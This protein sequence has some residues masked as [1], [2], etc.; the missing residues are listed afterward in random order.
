MPDDDSG[1]VRTPHSA[2]WTYLHTARRSYHLALGAILVAFVVLAAVYWRAIPPLEAPGEGGAYAIVAKRLCH[3]AL[4]AC[5]DLTKAVSSA[6]SGDRLLARPPLYAWLASASTFW[7]SPI[8]E[9][10]CRPNIYASLWDPETRGNKNAVLHTDSQDGPL[11]GVALAL[12][13]LRAL[14]VLTSLGTIILTYGL[15]R[16]ISPTRPAVALGASALVAFNP[17]FVFIGA[18][19]GHEAPAILLTTASLYCCLRI[20]TGAD[21]LLR[22]Q[23]RPHPLAERWPALS[24]LLWPSIIWR[25]LGAGLLVGLTALAASYGPALLLPLLWACALCYKRAPSEERIVTVLAALAGLGASLATSAWWY[26]ASGWT[27]TVAGFSP[28][29]WLASS[30]SFPELL[31]YTYDRWIVSYWGL[32]G[33]GNVRM[34]SGLAS[35][36]AILGSAGSIGLLLVAARIRWRRG[37]LARYAGHAVSLGVLWSVLAGVCSILVPV[38]GSWPPGHRLLPAISIISLLL[39]VG[40]GAWVK[41]HHYK[42]LVA[43]VAIG[44][45]GVAVSIPWTAISPAYARPEIGDLE[46]LPGDMSVLDIAYGDD[47]FLLGYRLERESVTPEG[48][49]PLSLYWLCRRR[50]DK[51][52]AVSIELLGQDQQPVGHLETHPGLGNYP[53]SQWVPGQVIFDR[54]LVPID[55]TAATPV[56]AQIRVGLVDAADGHYVTALDGRGNALGERALL[57]R[58]RLSSTTTILQSPQQATQAVFAERIALTGYDLV[59]EVRAGQVL[60][61]ICYW[62]SLMQMAGDYTVFIHILNRSGDIVAQVD[63]QPLHGDYPTSYWQTGERIRDSHYVSLPTDLAAGQY[64]IHLGLYRLDTGERLPVSATGSSGGGGQDHVSLGHLSVA[65]ALGD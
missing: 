5:D 34:P 22:P 21:S 11:E 52:Y 40:L 14:S 13:I 27:P 45:W 49:L 41:S 59:S 4:P 37:R 36:L 64:E 53:T 17:S 24:R 33:W 32:F 2:L 43:L 3:P 54:Y 42:W 25:A 28:A 16:L 65:P 31:A 44:V 61:V 10:P 19:A 7:I 63:E 23:L 39:C 60:S 1:Q 8:E 35:G 55:S 58:V 9:Q 38:P 6:H 29:A 18:T 26:I 47:V 62:Q 20:A 51:N 30:R 56:A 50:T 48:A 46:H 57:G 15:A 12:F